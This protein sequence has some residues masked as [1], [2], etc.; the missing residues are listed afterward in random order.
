MVAERTLMHV[1]LFEIIQLLVFGFFFFFFFGQRGK[2][3]YVTLL[4]LKKKIM[5]IPKL[6]E[7]FGAVMK[8]FLRK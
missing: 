5:L 6:Q 8:I 2:N 3:P 1:F 4:V 7:E